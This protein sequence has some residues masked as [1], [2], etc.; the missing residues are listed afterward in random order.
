MERKVV[1]IRHVGLASLIQ[2]LRMQARMSLAVT[3]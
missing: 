3:V 1:L 2:E